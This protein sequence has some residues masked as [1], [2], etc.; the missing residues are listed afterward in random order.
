VGAYIAATYD[1][2][3]FNWVK[4]LVPCSF[5]GVGWAL[6]VASIS[7]VAINT[8]PLHFAGMGSATTNLL[9]DLGFT[10]GPVVGGSIALSVANSR[11]IPGLE[12]LH[13][14]ASAAGPVLGIARQ[15]GAVAINSIPTLPDAVHAV[16]LTVLGSGFNIAY[17]VCAIAATVAALLT[18]FG[19]LGTASSQPHGD[20]LVDLAHEPAV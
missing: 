17:L 19:L 14:P 1:V 13:L 15:G 12:A 7:A 4:F 18:L 20:E 9:R 8:V 2:H 11:L 10:L 3:D 6:T 16:A 5:V